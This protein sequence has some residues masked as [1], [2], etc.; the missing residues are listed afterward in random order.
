MVMD[1]VLVQTQVVKPIE[2]QVVALQKNERSVLNG[3]RSEQFVPITLFDSEVAKVTIMLS[4][5]LEKRAFKG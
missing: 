5:E 3:I 1:E 2:L 4:P